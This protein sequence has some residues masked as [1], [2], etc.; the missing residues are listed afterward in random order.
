MNSKKIIAVLVTGAAIAGMTAA[1]YAYSTYSRWTAAQ[2]PYY[3]NPANADVTANAAEL[4][5]QSGA[6]AWST[7]TNPS[8]SLT[9]AGRV[10]DT[11]TGYDGRNVVIFRNATSGGAIAS[12]YLLVGRVEPFA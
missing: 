5:L 2:V 7:Q 10:N 3:I 6:A 9:Y 8:I 4:A 12:T 1:S 11:T